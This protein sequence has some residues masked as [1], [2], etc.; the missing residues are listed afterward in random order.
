MKTDRTI[1]FLTVE[2]ED[3]EKEANAVSIIFSSLDYIREESKT[4]AEP[5]KHTA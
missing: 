2:A 3:A 4:N 5:G 1:E